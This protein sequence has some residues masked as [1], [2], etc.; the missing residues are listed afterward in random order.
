VLVAGLMFGP[1]AASAA[2]KAPPATATP[3][4]VS[5]DR[6]AAKESHRLVK[7]ASDKSAKSGRQQSGAQSPDPSLESGSFFRTPAGAAVL[8][9]FGVG[10]GYALYSSSNDRI[11]SSGR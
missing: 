7:D 11:R 4:R 2:E 10:L 1:V 5:L 8:V 9:A 6:V 3:L